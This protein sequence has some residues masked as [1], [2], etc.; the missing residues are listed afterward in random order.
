MPLEIL[1]IPA[2][3]FG[4]LGFIRGLGAYKR[5]NSNNS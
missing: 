2:V 3:I 4:V 5:A 1:A